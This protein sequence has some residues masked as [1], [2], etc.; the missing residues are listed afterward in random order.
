MCVTRERPRAGDTQRPRDCPLKPLA[1]IMAVE[2]GRGSRHSHQL[3]PHYIKPFG[4]KVKDC[5]RSTIA[6]I[7]SNVGVCGLMVGYT[8]MGAFVFQ[9]IEAPYETTTMRS[10]DRIRNQTIQQLW[11][12]TVEYNVLYKN[13]WTDSVQLVVNHYQREII[14]AVGDGW[15]G[16]D[17]SNGPSQWSIEGGFLY[18]LTVITTIGTVAAA[19]HSPG[20][21]GWG[22]LWES[23][24][25][26]LRLRSPQSVMTV[27]VSTL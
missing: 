16:A 22:S 14:A 3:P 8:I 18:S 4:E 25:K 9:Y 12:I 13:N 2:R 19:F 27:S 21:E 10:V 26:A 1:L 6:F 20:G 5:C 7:F 24:L 15:D 11:N 17:T 23:V